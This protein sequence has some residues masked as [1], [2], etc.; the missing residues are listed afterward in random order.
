MGTNAWEKAPSAKIR[1]SRLGILKAT[2]KASLAIPA[3]N[4]RATIASRI[5]PNTREKSVM[6]LTAA[7]DF[8]KF[9]VVFFYS[10]RTP[11]T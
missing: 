3:P 1:R 10:A 4:T 2:K 7:S 9:M 6:E 5:N 8:N 11:S